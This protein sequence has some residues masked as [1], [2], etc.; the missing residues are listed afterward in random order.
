MQ[1]ELLNVVELKAKNEI[2]KANVVSNFFFYYCCCCIAKN[3][4][5][6]NNLSTENTTLNVIDQN[7]MDD[8]DHVMLSDFHLSSNNNKTN[9]S[10]HDLDEPLFLPRQVSYETSSPANSSYL[11]SSFGNMSTRSKSNITGGRATSTTPVGSLIGS[12]SWL[13]PY[14]SVYEINGDEKEEEGNFDHYKLVL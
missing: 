4:L 14:S 6:Y 2:D 7:G 9:K 13:R 11:S 5:K 8:G 12:S 1:L 10:P 3:K